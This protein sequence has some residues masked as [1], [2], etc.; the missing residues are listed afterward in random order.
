MKSVRHTDCCSCQDTLQT[1]IAKTVDTRFGIDLASLRQCLWRSSA[2]GKP[3]GLMLE[4]RLANFNRTIHCADTAVMVADCST[5]T[6]TETYLLRV[7]QDIFGIT[8]RSMKHVP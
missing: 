8:S 1:P 7:I 5:K 6:M 4:D 2:S 3:N